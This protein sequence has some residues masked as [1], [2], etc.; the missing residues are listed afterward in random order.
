MM[1]M[2]NVLLR[3]FILIIIISTL[4][5]TRFFVAIRAQ[6]LINRRLEMLITTRVVLDPKG[7]DFWFL[8]YMRGIGPKRGS[9]I[10]YFYLNS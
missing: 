8:L 6:R 1:M 10:N 3:V 9:L 7:D 4:T 5:M 2:C